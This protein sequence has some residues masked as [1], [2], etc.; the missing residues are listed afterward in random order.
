MVQ[1]TVSQYFFN[2]CVFDCLNELLDRFRPFG[3]KGRPPLCSN[4][5]FKV[6]P[7]HDIVE[8]LTKAFKLITGMEVGRIVN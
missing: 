2:H 5:E 7:F 4:L 1:S 6:Q 8:G 3:M